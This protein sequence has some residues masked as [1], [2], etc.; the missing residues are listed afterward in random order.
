MLSSIIRRKRSKKLNN[1]VR[2]RD[3]SMFTIRENLNITEI[4]VPSVGY[5]GK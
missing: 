1:P 4:P 3:F 5:I 2:K